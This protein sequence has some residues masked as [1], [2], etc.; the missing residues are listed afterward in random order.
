MIHS[1]FARLIARKFAPASL[2]FVG[3]EAGQF[4]EQSRK[5]ALES[6]GCAGV[7]ELDAL[8]HHQKEPRFDLAIWFY[9]P[10]IDSPNDDPVLDRL[11]KLADNLVLIPGA[12]ADVAKR[13]PRLVMQLAG[14]GFFPNYECDVVEIEPG[15][16]R[17]SRKKADSI[18][19]LLPAVETGF[20]RI[21]AQFRRM[22]RT[23]RTRM[24]ELEAADRHIALLEE[25]VLKLK[26]AKRD[27][28]QLRVE[29][30]A[31]RKSPERKIGQV[32][33]APYRLP[34]KLIREVRKRLGGPVTPKNPVP[35]P[36][37]Y[38]TWFER[39]R[40]TPAQAAALRR[41]ARSFAD[42]PLISII[43]PVFNTP[44]V[45]LEEAVA[46][47]QQQAYEN[48]ELLLVDDASTDCATLE[49]LRKIEQRDP[50]LRVLHLEKNG[51][52]SA[53][54][55]LGIEAARGTWMSLLDH[56]DVLEPDALFQTVKMLQQH[57]DADLIYSDED[58]LTEAGFEAPIFKP[59]WSPDFFL[60]YNYLCHFTTV[61]LALVR[62]LGGFRSAYDFAQ[63]YD[64]FLRVIS[65]TG[66]I[67]H[68]PRVLYHWRRS[69]GSTSINIRSKPNALE[70]ARRGLSDFLAREQQ[71]GH[72]AIDW[73]THGFRIRRHF[74]EEKKISIII[75]TRDRIDLL[76]RCIAS[77]EAK[78]SY[79]NYEIVL[80]DND[81]QSEEAREFFR[82][83]PHRLL[84]YEGPFN[85]SAINNFAV[86]NTE[87][88][89][90]L[91]LN[92]DTEVISN[93]WLTAMAEHVQR[94]EVGAVGARLL[95]R[96]ETIQHAGV[97]LGVRG[98]VKH[99]FYR[100]PAESPGVCRQLQVTRNYSAVTGACL[101]TR[102][103]VFQEVGG[104][105]EEH[106]PVIF[107]DVDLCLKMRQAG[108]FIVYTPFAKLYHDQSASRRASVE[109]SEAAV[110]RER[111][112]EMVAHD[113]F[114]NPNLSR[115]R[116][117]FSLG[118]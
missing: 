23:L 41:E 64:L 44:V 111:W 15:A 52:I 43:T 31:L 95:F 36:N 61:R 3:N 63:D 81:S 67:H 78:T 106:L 70:A 57:P 39:H 116:A 97:V 34:Q 82:D 27:L 13:R 29:K 16:V 53:A 9:P 98:M 101:L 79:E 56:D 83:F 75:A 114:Y 2:L 76:A 118:E 10:E 25:K 74:K 86:E 51:G 87:A 77:V 105:D 99:A 112:P 20:A 54:S 65:R 14:L 7:A 21:N 11:T 69:E 40:V 59:D 100:F 90:L 107:N 85:Y 55:N 115:E 30:Q 110:L 45:W 47:V 71:P 28:K 46:S 50:R 60:S 5:D 84:R 66:R 89:W 26:Q 37:E 103:S 38:Q 35:T 104:F 80:V 17:L 68:V 22:R 32:I 18:D 24:S 72:V 42:Q 12:G 93:E 102:R 92:N 49:A 19:T 4:S 48:W 6:T 113:P 58:K 33:L 108:Y 91:F 117:D 94:P 1:D 8:L 88:P 109:P 73:R 96:D 62:N